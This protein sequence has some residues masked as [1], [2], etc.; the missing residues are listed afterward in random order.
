MTSDCIIYMTLST[1]VLLE[2]ALSTC[3]LCA[4]IIICGTATCMRL[5]NI[6]YYYIMPKGENVTLT[7]HTSAESM[8][9]AMPSTKKGMFYEAACFAA[10]G[11]TIPV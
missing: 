9:N 4:V 2:H 10:K 11:P 7:L 6:A 3:I 5:Y 1:A 8:L